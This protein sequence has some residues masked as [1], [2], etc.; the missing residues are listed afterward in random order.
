MC[1]CVC[2]KKILTL[3]VDHL[4]PTAL[5]WSLLIRFVG[6]KLFT[7]RI[8]KSLSNCTGLILVPISSYS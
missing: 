8:R 1:V 3:S 7:C 2:V 6:T 4:I 5:I